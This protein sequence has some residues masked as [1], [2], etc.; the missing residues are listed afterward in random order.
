[1]NKQV[2]FD[3][4]LGLL[5]RARIDAARGPQCDPLAVRALAEGHDPPS[6][7][8]STCL[9][10]QY[11][12]SVL[13]LEMEDPQPALPLSF[14]LQI[15]G[16]SLW[17]A[18]GVPVEFPD[19]SKGLLRIVDTDAGEVRITLAQLQVAGGFE[20]GALTLE[21]RRV[22]DP[23]GERTSEDFRSIAEGY[24]V[25]TPRAGLEDEQARFLIRL[26]KLQALR[27]GASTA[28][29]SPEAGE[30]AKQFNEPASACA[31]DDAAS[32]PPVEHDETVVA[33]GETQAETAT[34]GAGCGKFDDVK[35]RLKRLL[36]ILLEKI[37]MARNLSEPALQFISPRLSE[38]RGR[39]ILDDLRIW[40]EEFTHG[41][42][43]GQPPAFPRTAEE[44]ED[45]VMAAALRRVLE[46]CRSGEPEWA[47]Q[48]RNE[49][50]RQDV[51]T[52]RGLYRVAKTVK[53]GQEVSS[54][55]ADLRD[56]FDQERQFWFG[57]WAPRTDSGVD[58]GGR[59]R[60]P[61]ATSP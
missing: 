22:G 28:T 34:A 59:A 33:A 52:P 10:C 42:H 31:N 60:T 51:A 16:K 61:D 58:G 12:A 11:D 30:H 26:C 56:Q 17:S 2:G 57:A 38:M 14:L 49:A 40:L 27:T 43:R 32:R 1:M 48:I 36:P 35:A 50:W 8:A 21:W 24:R 44:W 18:E 45:K 29:T 15:H 39:R 6:H 46:D 41:T 37:G 23:P 4:V 53:T 3:R 47:R 20:P 5:P 25:D 7:H 55:L 13:R 19:H 9:A 54:F